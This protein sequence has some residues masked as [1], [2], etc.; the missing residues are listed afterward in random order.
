MEDALSPVI[1]LCGPSG[2]GKTAIL[3]A[4]RARALRSIDV[5]PLTTT[6]P[7]RIGE[8]NGLEYEFVT[9]QSFLASLATGQFV[10]YTEHHGAL[11]GMRESLI[12]PYL[13]SAI[14]AIF[15]FGTTSAIRLK[16]AYPNQVQLCFVYPGDVH[17]L[18]RHGLDP[19]SP[20]NTELSRRLF[21]RATL[22]ERREDLE[23]WLDIR[24]I[25]NLSRIASVLNELD[26]GLDV[27]V[28]RNS[29]NLEDAIQFI[30]GALDRMADSTPRDTAADSS[31]SNAHLPRK[32]VGA[33]ALYVDQSDQILI[34]KP[35]YRQ[36]WLTPGGTVE[37][38]ESP[39]EGCR[40]EVREEL[41]SD[42]PV[43]R[44]ICIEYRSAHEAK[45]ENLQFV[46]WGGVL[47]HEQIEGLRLREGELEK[48]RFCPLED[49]DQFLN[50]TLANR[51]TNA[52]H[53]QARGEVIYLEDRSTIQ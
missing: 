32:R 9:Q 2:A 6:R 33:T 51:V 44:L 34:V 15:I 4:I 38:N 46:F 1:A 35:A 24:T 40:R 3:N 11:Y 7:P 27:T 5:V 21:E 43:H 41:G 26:H 49:I 14:P 13:A 10:D 29:T 19:L 30:E 18:R 52:V 28:I 12:R 16:K 20:P 31:Y 23:H 37:E 25:R 36:G 22:T 39:Y 50:P 48:Y 8:V 45:V 53:A 47:N 42:L 17:D